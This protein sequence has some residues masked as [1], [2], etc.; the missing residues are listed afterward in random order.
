MFSAKKAVY[1]VMT[2]RNAPQA[3]KPVYSQPINIGANVHKPPLIK[4]LPC[5]HTALLLVVSHGR[6]KSV[7][8]LVLNKEILK[9]QNFD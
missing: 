6:K 3:H 1:G 4:F 9:L 2:Q 5:Q 7:C 8:R